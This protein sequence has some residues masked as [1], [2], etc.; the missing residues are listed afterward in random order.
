MHKYYQL[1]LFLVLIGKF[2][3]SQT[4]GLEWPKPGLSRAQIGKNMVF[5][6][7]EWYDIVSIY[8]YY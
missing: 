8:K 2:D 6:S 3:K 5:K 7:R 1:T 4:F